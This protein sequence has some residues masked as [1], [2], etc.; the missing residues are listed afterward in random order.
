VCG[1]YVVCVWYV[2]GVCLCLCG[3]YVVCVWYVCG[4]CV[5]WVNIN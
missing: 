5:L 1:M 3:M 2:C 4:V